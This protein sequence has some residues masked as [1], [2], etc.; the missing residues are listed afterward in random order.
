MHLTD[1]LISLKL[2]IFQASKHKNGYNQPFT[3]TQYK[4]YCPFRQEL[5]EADVSGTNT[6]LKI[7]ATTDDSGILSLVYSGATSATGTDTV[8]ILGTTYTIAVDNGV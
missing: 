2:P 8:E 6:S 1:S 4:T 5:E 3:L 7:K